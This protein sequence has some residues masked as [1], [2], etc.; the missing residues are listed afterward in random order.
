MPIGHTGTLVLNARHIPKNGSWITFPTENPIVLLNTFVAKEIPLQ[1]KNLF[2]QLPILEEKGIG[3]ALKRED[4]LHPSISGNKYRKLKYN[5]VAAIDNGYSKV[6]TFGGAYSNHIAAT[7]FAA[8]N[9]GIKSIGVIRGEELEFTWQENPTL[10]RA[11]EDGMILKFVS[12]EAY[13]KKESAQFLADLKKEFGDFYCLPEGGT[14]AL[15]IK[16]CEEI[17]NPED[18][19]FDKI[20]TCVGT[21]GTLAGLVN[22]SLE[23]QQVLGFSALKGDFLNSEI[24]KMTANKRW[25][26]IT[27]YHFGGYG[28]INTQLVQFI[29]DFKE[30]THIPLDPIYTGKMLYGL[31]D[32]IRG[33][34]F[35]PGTKILAI[36]T[37]GL[38][39]ITGMNML[40]EKKHLPLLDI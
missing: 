30:K 37:G 9:K 3:L 22:S 7:S 26:L 38:Q 31:L 11:H 28:K 40:L 12:R 27:D 17:L 16:G 33:D 24:Q 1:S 13:R 29:N 4:L 14:N 39:G 2:L 25:K 10:K 19:Q 35:V 5:L 34:T 18:K 36:H 23:H 8:S 20:C 21:G 15:A 6:L 32:M